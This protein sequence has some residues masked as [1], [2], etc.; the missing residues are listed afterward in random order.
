MVAGWLIHGSLMDDSW[1]MSGNGQ[2]LSNETIKMFQVR[3]PP[4]ILMNFGT[5]CE[6]GGRERKREY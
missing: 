4:G 2:H 5:G 6:P 3:L 1:L